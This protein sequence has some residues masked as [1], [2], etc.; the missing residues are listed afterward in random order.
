MLPIGYDSNARRVLAIPELLQLIFSFGTQGS[1]VT[2]AL[3]CRGWRDAALDQVWRE[4][5]DLFVLLRLL[6]PLQRQ[7]L[8]VFTRTPTPADWAR[9]V[10]YAR[11]VR[12]LVF[13]ARADERSLLLDDC[14]FHDLARTRSTLEILPNLRRLW[15]QHTLPTKAQH[16]VLFMHDK[17]TEFAF[18]VS[19]GGN[20]L[21]MENALERMPSLR[22]L[23]CTCLDMFRAEGG[24]EMLRPLLTGLQRLQKVALPKDYLDGQVL[25]M[26]SLLPELQVIQFDNLGGVKCNEV[27]IHS[28]VEEGA[29]PVLNDLCLDSTLDDMRVY[30]TGG[31]LL[32]RL[33]KLSVE[34]VYVENP[35]AVQQFMTDVVRCY[36][37]LELFEIDVIVYVDEQDACEALTL[38]HIRPILSLKQLTR[39]ELR[40]NM[41]LQISESDLAEMGVALPAVEYLVLNPEPLA[42]LKPRLSLDSLVSFA[43][44]FPNLCHLGLYLNAE[45][46]YMHASLLDVKTRLFPHLRTIDVGVSPI[47]SDHVPVALYLSHLLAENEMVSVLSGVAW[48]DDLYAMAPLYVEQVNERCH[49]W[50]EVARTLPLLLQLR[51]EEKQHR[52]DIEKE[53]EDLRMRNEVL[54]GTVQMNGEAKPIPT[55]YDKGCVVC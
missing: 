8:Y 32:P 34:S 20:E 49:G 23:T 13:G 15:W 21:I 1:N 54:M 28:M 53:V 42:L 48:H 46:I 33:K 41:P 3:V 52:Q 35:T 10:P 31:A 51:K 45:G 24:I 38:E 39:L 14:V 17:V 36:P 55:G 26:L 40:H 29:F 9:F 43:Q 22:T 44:N 2:N 27:T 16:A 19:S 25:R 6:A 30:L 37:S 11:R 18:D 5:D 47:G 4:V 12:S 7:S 50:A